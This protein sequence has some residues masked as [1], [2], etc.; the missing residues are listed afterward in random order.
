MK[1]YKLIA[2][3]NNGIMLDDNFDGYEG[4]ELTDEED[5]VDRLDSMDEDEVIGAE[6][7]EETYLKLKEEYGISNRTGRKED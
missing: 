1:T 2:D 4:L 5:F 3:I 7:T 6:V